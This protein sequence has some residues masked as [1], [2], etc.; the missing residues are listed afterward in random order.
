MTSDPTRITAVKILQQLLLQKGSLS[1]LLDK[2]N[3]KDQNDNAPVLQALCYGFCRYYE[4]LVF[5]SGRFITKPLRKKD[6][7]Y[8]LLNF[9]RNLSIIFYAHAR[10]RCHQ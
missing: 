2:Y 4:Q 9:D 1:T 5:I 6:S 10:L 8:S 7:R 3:P